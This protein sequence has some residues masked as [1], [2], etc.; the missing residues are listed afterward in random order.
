[1]NRLNSTY[2]GGGSLG[3]RPQTSMTPEALIASRAFLRLWKKRE[4]HL[5]GV[6][7]MA[8]RLRHWTWN[9]ENFWVQVQPWLLAG[10]VL[11]SCEFQSSAIGLKM[12]CFLPLELFMVHVRY[13]IYLFQ[14]FFQP[15]QTLSYKYCRGLM[16]VNYVS[17][18]VVTVSVETAFC[19][20]IASKHSKKVIKVHNFEVAVSCCYIDEFQCTAFCEG[21]FPLWE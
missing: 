19:Y 6:V 1:M 8:M 18:F 21:H 2:S 14:S 7:I 17:F 16:A 3:E 10:V 13:L 20:W 12:V 15:L 4:K 11:S 5:V 9:K